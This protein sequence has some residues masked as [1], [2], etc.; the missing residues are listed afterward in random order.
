[1]NNNLYLD[2]H[3]LQSLP[4]A[5]LNR[6]DSGSPKTARFGGVDRLRV[7]SQAW[8][9]AMR[10]DFAAHMNEGDLGF[11]TKR[12]QEAIARALASEGVDE[13]SIE[14]IATTLR[15]QLKQKPDK[16]GK[17]SS[18]TNESETPN[19]SD[20]SP[21]A[22][23]LFF[24]SRK[25][26]NE[27]A[28]RIA[29][30]PE[31][32]SDEKKLLEL[33][34]VKATMGRGHSFDVA[35]S[36]R[37]VANLA[38]LNVDAA[39]QMAHAIST[40]ATTTQFDYFTAV[41]ELRPKEETGAGMINT[42]EFDSATLYRYATLSVPA[43][44]ENMDDEQAALEGIGQFL[45]SFVLAM[46]TGKQNTFAAHT[47][48]ELVYVVVRA[49]QPVNLAGA[50]EKP[51]RPHGQGYYE[52]SAQALAKHVSG[53]AARWGD[54]PLLA[55]ASYQPADGV[56]EALGESVPFAQLVEQVQAF[57]T[58]AVHD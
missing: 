54:A 20:D 10:L 21:D 37:M 45:R 16:S 24:F 28:R 5:N 22:E 58:E 14:S 36:G 40:H 31:T 34:A 15:K 43:L 44:I 25:Q 6:D 13:D 3:V 17:K 33:A 57:I 32:W 4:P 7:S 35:L 12:L 46:P 19:K 49:D 51:V 38:E 42:I 30:H 56:T 11:R 53:E 18:T 27:I 1:M 48:P 23:A 8:K 52:P 50:F 2:V 26:L 39:M 9:R 29:D 47:R 41:D 55:L